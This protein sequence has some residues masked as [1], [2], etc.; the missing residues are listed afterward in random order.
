MNRVTRVILAEDSFIVREGLREILAAQPGLDVAAACGDLDGLLEAVA[1][2]DPDV[3][4][5]D[6]NMPVMDGLEAARRMMERTRILSALE[7]VRG[8]PSVDL[9][10]LLLDVL[11]LYDNLR[12][13]V[14]LA[15]PDAPVIVQGEPTRLRQ[16]FHNLLQNAVDAQ[17][18]ADQP[19]YDPSCTERARVQRE[20]EISEA[21]YRAI[22]D[23]SNDAIFVHD[24]TTGAVLHVYDRA[25]GVRH[26]EFEVD[27]EPVIFE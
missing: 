14:A 18:G 12:P 17:S 27:R 5:T 10:S 22:F 16:V 25:G 3:V 11:A 8:R 4:I 19:P 13:H 20:L 23:A 15:L 9:A 2:H 26:G 7:G 6:I 21:S 24:A 1:E